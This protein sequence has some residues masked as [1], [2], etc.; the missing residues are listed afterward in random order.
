MYN[1]YD[2][3]YKSNLNE[4]LII[5][6][7]LGIIGIVLSIFTIFSLSKV[8][9]KANRSGIA[10][11]IPIYNV[12]Q[13]VEI[14]NLPILYFILTFIPFVNIYAFYKISMSIAILFKK[15]STFGLGLFLLPFVFYPILAF[16]DS[17][18][19]GINLFALQGTTTVEDIP[20]IDN[21]KNQEIEVKI[22]DNYDVSSRNINISIGGGKYQKDYT[23]NLVDV[24]KEKIVN[25]AE[26][27]MNVE[28][29]STGTFINTKFINELEANN[30][31]EN[32]N[33]NNTL[34]A[35]E[36]PNFN[37]NNQTASTITDTTGEYNLCPNCGTRVKEN[38]KICF[39]CG[40]KLQ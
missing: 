8:Y 17:E 12:Y 13:L 37:T 29:H 10:P 3:I 14:S 35:E 18:Y 34:S 20:V 38:S 19:I 36:S 40:Y 30:I 27:E 21:N 32:N 11:W 2:V 28:K 6:I 25:K 31:S 39:V 26:A 1:D 7:I 9:K 22:N 33:N 16:S 5:W 24:D 15:N 23:A 4:F